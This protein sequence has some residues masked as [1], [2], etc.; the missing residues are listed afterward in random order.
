M[1]TYM[2]WRQLVLQANTD[3]IDSLRNIIN[4][5]I[6]NPS[7]SES[8]A[9][10]VDAS[11]AVHDQQLCQRMHICIIVLPGV[12]LWFQLARTRTEACA[13][14]IRRPLSRPKY[15]QDILIGWPSKQDSRTKL[16]L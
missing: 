5:I 1:R 2:G 11:S 14:K 12:N 15:Y 7:R 13:Q 4:S 3:N 10:I 16:F 9:N 6:W 8:L